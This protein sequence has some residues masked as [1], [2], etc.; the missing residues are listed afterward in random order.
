MNIFKKLFIPNGEKQELKAYESWSV[1]W[2]SRSGYN[3]YTAIPA[4][5]VFTSKKDATLFAEQ[6]R[7]A[8]KLLR[9][10]GDYSET[11]VEITKN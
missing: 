2:T 11:D 8:F 9:F 10:K 5:E 6:L 3:L 7:E 1:R 4:A